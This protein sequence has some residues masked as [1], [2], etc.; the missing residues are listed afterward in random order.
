MRLSYFVLA[1]ILCCASLT[2]WA[3]HIP[4]IS[5]SLHALGEVNSFVMY[6]DYALFIRGERHLQIMDF[7]DAQNPRLVAGCDVPGI[8]AGARSISVHGQYAYLFFGNCFAIISLGNPLSPQFKVKIETNHTACQSIHD[9]ILYSTSTWDNYL[10]SYSLSDPLAPQLLDSLRVNNYPTNIACGDGFLVCGNTVVDIVDTSDPCN[11][12]ISGE[13]RFVSGFEYASSAFA[14]SGSKLAVGCGYDFSVYDLIQEPYLGATLPLGYMVTGGKGYIRNNRFWCTCND[15]HEILGI[16][17]SDFDALEICYS[18][19]IP[20]TVTSSFCLDGNLATIR[21]RYPHSLNYSVLVDDALPD[22]ELSY[23]VEGIGRIVSQGNWTIGLISGCIYILDFDETGTAY[24]QYRIGMNGGYD[25]TL[26]ND[27]LLYTT[28]DEPYQNGD[29]TRYLIL[30]DLIS[31]TQK[32]SL[33]LGY[34]SLRSDIVLDGAMAYIC[35]RNQGLFVVDISNIEQPVLLCQ[36]REG[37][38]DNCASAANGK[39][40]VGSRF[41]INCYDTGES[42]APVFRYEI[43]LY[44]HTPM[45]NPYKILMIDDYLYAIT[46]NGY[47]ARIEPGSD[48]AAAIGIYQTRYRFNTSLAKLGN[49]LLVGSCDGVSVYGLNGAAPP[50]ELAF[51]DVE[52]VEDGN[53]IVLTSYSVNGDRIYVGRVKSLQV[54]DA[55]LAIAFMHGY[56]PETEQNLR[57]Y[58]NPGKGMIKVICKLPADGEAELELYNLRG[59]KVFARIYGSI[60]EGLNVL[61]METRDD[62]GRKLGSG[63]Y[64]VRIKQGKHIQTGKLAIVK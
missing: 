48:G 45:I 59:Q 1:F 20:Y 33:A 53:S 34:S 10:Y 11:L 2:L 54:L 32:A 43:P 8:D 36:L 49:G 14:V 44:Y 28:L 61:R 42:T 16:D 62:S 18:E 23:P 27:I 6:G 52:R 17:F 35:N 9:G 64:F 25:I 29:P 46:T 12:R 31:K 5:E 24:L 37:I 57:I 58:P 41:S 21:T 22:F 15:G 50:E 38:E 26:Y 19:T 39:L 30:Y 56:F 51:R 4:M 7:S 40:W 55:S 3:D 63:M 13:L 60:T 47:L